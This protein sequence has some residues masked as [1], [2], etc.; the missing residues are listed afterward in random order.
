MPVL[1]TVGFC[2]VTVQLI[3]YTAWNLKTAVEENTSHLHPQMPASMDL[4]PD[5]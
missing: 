2:Y 1:K 4:L 3:N 5:T